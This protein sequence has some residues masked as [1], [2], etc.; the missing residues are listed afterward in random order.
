MEPLLDFIL[1]KYCPKYMQPNRIVSLVSLMLTALFAV[2]GCDKEFHSVGIELFESYGFQTQSETYPVFLYQEKLEKVQTDG[3]PLG[4][5]G[6]YQHPV[7]GKTEA[8]FTSQLTINPNPIFGNYSQ[9]NEDQGDPDVPYMIP[10]NETVTSVYLEIP[11]FNNQND[12]DQDGLIDRFDSDPEDPAS[13]TDGDGIADLIETQG[14]TNPLDIDSDGDGIE[15]GDDTDNST[16]DA[17][18][19]VYEI[20]SLL[21]NRNAQF[22][23]KVQEL[24]YYLSPLDPAYNFASYKPYFNDTDYE[25][26]GFT[27]AVLFE[28]QMQL[29]FEELR[30]NFTEDDPE[31]EVDETTQVGERL[32]PRIRVPLDTV[33]FQEN[34][35]DL[36]GTDALRDLNSFQS[37][38]K[39]IIVEAN[40][41][42]DDL[43]MLLDVEN[44]VI[45]V[46]Y[47]LD[48]Y[49]D[50]GTTDDLTDDYTT[51]V[52][53]TFN[54]LL[55][56]VTFN[57]VSHENNNSQIDAA[58]Q[59][60]IRNETSEKIWVKGGQ[61]LARVSLFGSDPAAQ[62][63]AIRPIKEELRLVSEANLRFY[64][65]DL[66][67]NSPSL[68]LP[69]RLYLYLSSS[70]NPLPDYAVDNTIGIGVTNGDKYI[71]GGLLQYT[72]AG[73][74]SHY[75]FTITENINA[76][77]EKATVEGGQPVLSDF[78]NFSLTLVL[79]ASIDRVDLRQAFLSDGRGKTQ[80]PTT[81]ALN[82]FGVELW[83][84]TPNAP[85]AEL[86]ILYNS[87]R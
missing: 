70:G 57:T 78:D 12:S 1:K 72:E 37:H 76:L 29:D 20:D 66:Y 36:E 7:F 46:T 58:V 34:L 39:G 50:A 43:M 31:T 82:P 33:F 45:K 32:S 67:T 87:T 38:L 27:G 22:T 3:L 68:Y 28:D 81:S 62:A 18:N 30:F 13:D 5:L 54:V 40:N 61:Y 74:P 71:L 21:G 51:Q 73:T 19:Q 83:G 84:H 2:L 56:G 48:F 41:F 6:S 42:S 23:L 55:S 44:A 16:Y 59:A 69:E 77:L 53:E 26:Q 60:G 14:G 35:I 24:T 79:G 85:A 63:A 86:E 15:D 75:E 47:T 10:E 8:H 4:Q 25:A 65:S 11:F 49:N 80:V 9:E 17:G 64:V 52:D